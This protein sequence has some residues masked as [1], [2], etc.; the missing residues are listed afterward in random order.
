[1]TI[2]PHLLNEALAD[3]VNRLPEGWRRAFQRVEM[4]ADGSGGTLSTFYVDA[5]NDR[6]VHSFAV[7]AAHHLRWRAIWRAMGDAPFT[8][9]SVIIEASGRFDVDYSYGPLGD[10]PPLVR[11]QR[12]LRRV[13]PGYDVRS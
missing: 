3:L 6:S 2:D 10:E 13:A 5:E 7:P 9:A 12:W 11:Q 4:Y 8:A 1:M